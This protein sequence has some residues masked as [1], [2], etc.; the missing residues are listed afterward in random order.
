MGLI[1]RQIG[2]FDNVAALPK[3]GCRIVSHSGA[4]ACG[5]ACPGYMNR[6]TGRQHCP[7]RLGFQVIVGRFH[8]TPAYSGVCLATELNGI[9][10]QG[11]ARI[12]H[13]GRSGQSK[14]LVGWIVVATIGRGLSLAFLIMKI[15]YQIGYGNLSLAVEVRRKLV[16]GGNALR[17]PR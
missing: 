6:L 14:A 3:P 7:S 16:A 8:V 15:A 11:K 10:S 9:S 13:P 17:L 1:K 5:N 12:R 2:T 4:L